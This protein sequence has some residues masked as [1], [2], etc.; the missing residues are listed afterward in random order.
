LSHH[1]SH[2]RSSEKR[3]EPST[4]G[5]TG[6]LIWVSLSDFTK[7]PEKEHL[8]SYISRNIY[9]NR[10]YKPRFEHNRRMRC[11]L[12][13]IVNAEPVLAILTSCRSPLHSSAVRK[14]RLHS[15]Q[16]SLTLHSSERPTLRP[17]NSIGWQRVQ[18]WIGAFELNKR[19]NSSRRL[20]IKRSRASQMGIK[21]WAS[22]SRMKRWA[23][24]LSK[25][26]CQSSDYYPNK[27]SRNNCNKI[28]MIGPLT[29]Y[30][31][32]HHKVSYSHSCLIAQ[33]YLLATPANTTR[34]A[35]ATVA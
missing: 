25:A 8:A 27:I 33:V 34:S 11:P 20:R 18:N 12:G 9:E 6:K 22:Q 3:R 19:S 1:R 10:R 5:K 23:K 2:A 30:A 29:C 17:K 24:R 26:Y 13:S 21:C 7:D 35:T 15:W 32:K 16:A 4:A 14:I 28:R 31:S